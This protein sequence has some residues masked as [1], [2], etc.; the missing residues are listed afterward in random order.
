MVTD[1]SYAQGKQNIMYIFVKSLLYAGNYFNMCVD[2][3][4]IKNGNKTPLPFFLFIRTNHQENYQMAFLMCGR[5]CI[6][7]CPCA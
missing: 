7:M 3:I 5:T 1:G 4:S 6:Y 2:H